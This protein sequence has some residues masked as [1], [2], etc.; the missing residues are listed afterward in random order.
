MF[1]NQL[2]WLIQLVFDRFV[3][4]LLDNRATLDSLNL[5]CDFLIM[6]KLPLEIDKKI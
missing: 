2:S 6:A 1:V 4:S 5:P 3:T